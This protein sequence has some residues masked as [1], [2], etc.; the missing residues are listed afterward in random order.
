MD[1]NP[2]KKLEKMARAAAERSAIKT[3]EFSSVEDL[4]GSSLASYFRYLYNT[5]PDGRIMSEHGASFDVS[6]EDERLRRRWSADQ[7]GSS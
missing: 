7:E 5:L 6:H 2:L 4:L 3:S 1:Y